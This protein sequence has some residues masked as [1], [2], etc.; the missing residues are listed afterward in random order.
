SAS[1][2]GDDPSQ[3]TAAAGNEASPMGSEIPSMTT[4]SKARSAGIA[5]A[6]ST[7]N[8]D[9]AATARAAGLAAPSEETTTAFERCGEGSSLYLAELSE[10]RGS[11]LGTD[12]SMMPGPGSVSS[13][14]KRALP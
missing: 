7:S 6:S 8:L 12:T 13:S 4:R 3:S 2:P 9:V 14:R 10:V 1:R 11:S 5:S